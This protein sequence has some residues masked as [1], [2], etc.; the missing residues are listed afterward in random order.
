MFWKYLCD[1]FDYYKLRSLTATHIG[2]DA[3][4]YTTHD[5]ISV[6]IEPLEGDGDFRS[7]ACRSILSKNDVVITNPPFSL[8]RE[9]LNLILD[10]K[11]DYII[12]GSLNAIS[13]KIIFP[14]L[15]Q[16][17]MKLGVNKRLKYFIQPDGTLKTF[18]NIV[19]FASMGHGITLPEIPLTKEYDPDKYPKYDNYNAIEVGRVADIPKDYYG[20]MGVPIT[21]MLKYNPEQFDIIGLD[22]YLSIDNKRFR[23]NG[24]IK[25]ARIVI[26]RKVE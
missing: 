11:K 4:V 5:G 8:F 26:K 22:N 14:L 17:K 18:G 2:L 3:K 13:Y 12:I 15:Q 9:L 7:P 21:F 19:W 1:N 6:L 24:D 16:G 23:I 25:Y 20:E 10:E